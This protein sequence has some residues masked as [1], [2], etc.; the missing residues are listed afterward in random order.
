MEKNDFVLGDAEV[1]RRSHEVFP[2]ASTIR[3]QSV[4]PVG[5][6]L[7]CFKVCVSQES[8]QS[9]AG[10]DTSRA[11]NKTSLTASVRAATSSNAL[12]SA[13]DENLAEDS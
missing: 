10:K 3:Q 12:R 8:L 4:F 5:L 11:N 7:Q 1:S 2:S 9:P 6:R 13:K